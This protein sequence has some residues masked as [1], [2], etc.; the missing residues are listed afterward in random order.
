RSRRMI[1]G[2]IAID[3]AAHAIAFNFAAPG[4][5]YARVPPVASQMKQSAGAEPFR[6]L[7]P[8]GQS[9]RIAAPGATPLPGLQDVPYQLAYA[10]ELR[11]RLG[12]QIA[13][14]YGIA[15]TYRGVS[16]T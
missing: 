9:G 5:F 1:P 13:E 14:A 8:L 10:E 16:L 7:K 2:L 3:L 11:N 15:G 6:F 12:G 4:D